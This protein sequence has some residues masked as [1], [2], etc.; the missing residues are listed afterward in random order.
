MIG[1]KEL[2]RDINSHFI[3]ERILLDGPVS[4]AALAKKSGLAKATVSTI[5]LELLQKNL[6]LE[7][8][9]D[10]TSM[11]R[12]PILLTF[13]AGCGH[14]L[15]LDVGAHTI[16]AMTCNLR[17]QNC[18]LKLYPHQAGREEILPLLISI[19]KEQLQ[20][21]EE[22]P[23]GL[24]GIGLGIHGTVDQNEVTFSPYAPYENLPF[25]QALEQAFQV[26]IYLENEANLSVIGEHTFCYHVPNLVGISIHTGIGTGIIIEN[27]LYKGG[28]GNAGEFGHTVIEMDGRSCPCGNQGCLEQYASQRAI[29]QQYREL[30]GKARA[31]IDD[32][33]A[34][35]S[36]QEAEALALLEDFVRYM[37]V[38]INNI[39]NAFNPDVIVINSLFTSYFPEVLIHI[40]S[41]LKNRMRAHCRLVPSGLQDASI[42]LGAACVCIRN[43]LGIEHL[44]LDLE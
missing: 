16:S 21:L 37:S 40:Q 26:P 9:N 14:V 6:I 36:H 24:V 20:D 31:S 23:F 10:D 38:G 4:R 41:R 2:I 17:G 35:C 44:R 42:L 7:I 18:R 27:T 22:T 32:F 25:R 19:V 5:V 8:G 3:L 30:P 11:G 34:A 29:M 33:V 13:H 43:F 1:S 39:L 12:K 28:N 15:S